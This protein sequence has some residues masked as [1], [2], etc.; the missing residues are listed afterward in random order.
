MPEYCVGNVILLF[1]VKECVEKLDLEFFF[2]EDIAL[3]FFFLKLKDNLISGFSQT[4]QYVVVFYLDDDMF[5]S[6]DHHQAIITKLRIR[7]MW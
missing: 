3:S 5:R 2:V 7:Y 4:Q 1:E 6:L